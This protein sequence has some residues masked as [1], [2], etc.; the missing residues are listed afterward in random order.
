MILKRQNLKVMAAAP[1]RQSTISSLDPVDW[2]LLP[3][4][5]YAE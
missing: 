1:M 5:A 4:F 3:K 2:P